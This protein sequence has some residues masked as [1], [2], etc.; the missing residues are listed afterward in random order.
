[1]LVIDNSN[2]K[3][4]EETFDVLMKG[5]EAFD[6]FVPLTIQELGEKPKEEKIKGGDIFVA[7]Q[8]ESNGNH[9]KGS[10]GGKTSRGKTR[11]K[12]ISTV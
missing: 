1:M 12:S 11:A 4:P 9:P 6:V 10:F 5:L 8:T 2:H 7:G 3:S